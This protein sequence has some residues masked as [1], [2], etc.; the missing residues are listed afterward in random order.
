M[1]H[2]FHD[3]RDEVAN[4]IPEYR[5][6]ETTLPVVPRENPLPPT[7][8]PAK[9][10]YAT[11]VFARNY[12]GVWRY[13]VQI[14]YEGY[15]TQT[16][17]VTRCLWVPSRVRPLITIIFT[18]PWSLFYWSILFRRNSRCH[19]MEGGCMSSPRWTSVLVAEIYYPDTYIPSRSKAQSAAPST[20]ASQS[21][22]N[23]VPGE[24]PPPVQDFQNY[25]QYLQKRAGVPAINEST[26]SSNDSKKSTH[27]DGVD[28][29]GCF[30]VSIPAMQKHATRHRCWIPVYL[31]GPTILRLVPC[32][33]QL[34]VLEAGL[35]LQVHEEKN[36]LAGALN[37]E[38]VF[39]NDDPCDWK[40]FIAVTALKV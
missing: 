27:C 5:R 26:D 8:C 21:H 18:E 2:G 7:P 20:W 40:E 35:L 10:E 30:Q 36:R 12:Q 37:F 16:I 34:Q 31:S 29:I 3:R 14:P 24:N 19:Y 1:N 9:V 15:F 25:Q 17:E 4:D 33:W 22:R 6:G 32:S 38:I 11:P 28:E 23:P 39:R 13:V